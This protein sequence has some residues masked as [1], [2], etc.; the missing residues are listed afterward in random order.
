MDLQKELIAE[1]EQEVATTRKMLEAIPAEA[2]FAYK[3]HP[4]SMPLGRVA[5][6]TA[7]TCGLWAVTTLRDNVYEMKMADFKPWLPANKTELLERFEKETTE[8]RAALAAFAPEK[9]DDSWKL[10][11]D[12]QTWIDEPKYKVWRTWVMNHMIHHRAQLGV[13][14]RLLGAPLPSTYGPSADSQ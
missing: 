8:S 3:P 14:L 10:V 13:Y 4:K 2:D 7:E 9:W 1:F 11:G 12:G 6:H 5:A